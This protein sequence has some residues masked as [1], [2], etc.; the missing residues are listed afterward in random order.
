MKKLS[1]SHR[2]E[3]LLSNKKALIC[4]FLLQEINNSIRAK[5]AK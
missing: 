4:C 3:D 1:S 5:I 2:N